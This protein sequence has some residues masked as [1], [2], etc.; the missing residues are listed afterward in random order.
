MSNWERQQAGRR[1]ADAA[2]AAEAAA[3][4]VAPPGVRANQYAGRCDRCGGT[5]GPGAGRLARGQFGG[6]V[7]SHLDS[8]DCR[9]REVPVSVSVASKP[10][11]IRRC[12]LCGARNPAGLFCPES[13][14]GQGGHR[15]ETV[16]PV[17]ASE[18]ADMQ[19]FLLRIGEHAEQGASER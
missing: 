13:S 17:S 12:T 18:A 19:R 6:W 3:R 14:D 1:A 11:G 7:V 5:V 9:R 4:R 15:L 2:H 16:E 8:A 10:N